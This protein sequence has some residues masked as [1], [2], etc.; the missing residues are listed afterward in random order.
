MSDQDLLGAMLTHYE[1]RIQACLISAKVVNSRGTCCPYQIAIHRKSE[2]SIEDAM[3]GFR[4]PGL[5][6]EDAV[7]PA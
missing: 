2:G 1:P 3:E 6:L 7:W 5:N 4:T